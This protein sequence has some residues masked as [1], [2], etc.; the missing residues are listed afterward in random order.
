MKQNSNS[1]L[2]SKNFRNEV[3]LPVSALQAGGDLTLTNLTVTND[4]TVENDLYVN[5]TVYANLGDLTGVP[6]P[7]G[8]TGPTGLQGIQGIQG[9][10]GVT[11]PTGF[12][13]LRGPTGSQGIQGIQGIQGTVGATGPTGSQG[14]QGTQGIQGIQGNVGSTGPTGYTG[15]QGI[16]GLQGNEGI[17]GTVGVTGPTGS[18][19]IQGTQGIQ[20]VQGNVGAT[21]PT[22]S[23]GI[24]GTQG[25]QGNVG[26]TGPT[27]SQGIQGTQGIQGIQGTVGA[28][29]PTG[30]TGPTGTFSTTATQILSNKSF[31]DEVTFIIDDVDNNKRFKF[32][33]APITAATTRTYSVPDADTTLAGTDIVQTITNKFMSAGNTYAN[34]VPFA[35]DIYDIGSTASRFNDIYTDKIQIGANQVLNGAQR[36]NIIGVNGSEVTGASQNFYTSG[37]AH[38]VLTFRAFAHDDIGIGFDTYRSAGSWVSGSTSSNFALT[39]DASNLTIYSS[40]GTTL[41]SAVAWTSALSINDAGVSNIRSISDASLF[42][43]SAAATKQMQ[44]DLSSISAGTTKTLVVCNVNGSIA[45]FS[46][47]PVANY[48]LTSSGTDGAAN[49]QEP[50]AMA[51]RQSFFTDDFGGVGISTIP[52]STIECYV[53][54]D[55]PWYCYSSVLSEI[56]IN[57]MLSSSNLNPG[58]MVGVLYPKFTTPA[59]SSERG[60]CLSNSSMYSLPNGTIRFDCRLKVRTTSSPI[61]TQKIFVGL[62]S[63]K[64]QSIIPSDVAPLIGFYYNS[65]TSANWQFATCTTVG[66]SLTTT[67]GSNPVT[68]GVVVLRFDLNT[69]GSFTFYID[70]VSVYSASVDP[71]NYNATLIGPRIMNAYSKDGTSIPADGVGVMYDYVNV[72]Q[73]FNRTF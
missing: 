47:T 23:Q 24:Q 48:I 44:L 14:I 20:G 66:F 46:G 52:I 42:S 43:S 30:Y 11:G 33:A 15:L 12:T 7:A 53:H 2:V 17:Q 27:G 3:K 13:G 72:R 31:I 59:A 65:A 38:P 5:G 71:T 51:L 60:Y 54:G 39:K 32:Q 70:G 25:I 64:W 28:T 35:N 26:A 16:Q 10:V 49:W 8:A 29:G 58:Q 50:N 1:W 22:G 69:N 37:N 55:K 9:N 67:V 56:D 40:P 61:A 68:G 57:G 62:G 6:G 45:T 63:N 18:Q 21:G 41:G 4:A 19:G 34:I 73:S 36:V